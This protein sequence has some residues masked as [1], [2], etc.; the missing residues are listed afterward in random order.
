VE[1]DYLWRWTTRIEPLSGSSASPVHF[2]QS[3]F[4][5]AVLSAAQLRRIAADYIPRLSD[6]GI[7]RRRTFEL[8][9]GKLSLEGIAADFGTEDPR[10]VVKE[11]G[12]E[13]PPT[14][15]PSIMQL[16]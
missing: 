4:A 11:H 16:Y 10:Q 15:K 12:A 13:T 7:L 1:N 6:E 9:D 3:Q 5:G 2:D 14:S 8:M